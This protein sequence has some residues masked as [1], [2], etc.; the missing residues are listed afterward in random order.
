MTPEQP[1]PYP[2]NHR[3]VTVDVIIAHEGGIVLVKRGHPPYEGQWALPGGFVDW[4]E[5]AEQAAI[6]EAKEETGLEIRLTGLVGVYSHPERDPGRQTVAICYRGE[7]VGG[8]LQGGDDA[9]EA[10]VFHSMA[11]R[12]LAFDHGEMCADAGV[13]VTLGEGFT[14]HD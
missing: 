11:A 5:T 2:P 12:Q 13:L 14:D 3:A 6:R 8:T 7:V 1:L 4:N 9:Q 10:R